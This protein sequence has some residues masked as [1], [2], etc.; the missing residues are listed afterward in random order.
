MKH[1]FR[2]DN[3]AEIP[4][5]D[6]RLRVL[7]EVGTKLLEK[8]DGT[9]ENCL[10]LANRSAAKLINIVVED[11]PCFND[12][13][14]YKGKHVAIYKRVQ[15]LVSDLKYFFGSG[16]LG[17]MDDLDS[18]TIFADYRLPQVLMYFGALSYTDELMEK[19][20]KG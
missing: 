17:A 11:F 7:Q 1:I 2:G 10:K 8:Y 20:K 4:L 18:L 9:F 15:I 16:G 19:I 3:E 5:F 6:Q 12:V 14:Q 13:A